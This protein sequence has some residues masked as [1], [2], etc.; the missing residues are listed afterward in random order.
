MIARRLRWLL[1]IAVCWPTVGAS[2]DA[3]SEA[4]TR[5]QRS[6]GHGQLPQAQKTLAP[7]AS[8]HDPRALALLGRIHTLRGERALAKQRY[9]SVVALYNRGAIGERDG[10]G[11][12][13]LATATAALGAYR[14]ANE[15]FARAVQAAPERLDIEL[16]WADL[17]IEK[18]ALDEAA[19]GVARVLAEAPEH[20]RALELHARI[21]LERGANFASVEALLTRALASDASLTAAHVTRAGLALRDEDVPLADGQ[22]DAALAIN[23]RDLEALSVRAA[24]RFVADDAPGFSRAVAAVLAQNARFSRL[25]SI[26]A[27]YAEWQH[28]YPELV[29]LSEAALAIDPGD[30]YA[31]AARGINLLRIGRE[32]EGLDALKQAWSRDHYNVQVFNLLELYERTLA[33]EYD[34]FDAPHFRLRMQKK[35]RMALAPYAV[36]LLGRAYDTLAKRY[37][38]TP[39]EPTYVELYASP[40][41][42]SIR[43]TGLPKLGVQGIC[44]GNVLIALSPRGGEFSWAQILWHELSHV[45]H[46]QLSKGRVPRWFTEGLAE[47]ET[48]LAEREWKR[49]D[50]RALYDALQRGA[51]PS[52]M[53]LNHA[54]THARRPDELMV[55]YYASALAVRYIAE[56]HGEQMLPKL[57]AL[58]GDGHDTGEVF[59]RAL[60]SELAEL[61]RDFRAALATRLGER[62]RHDMR[63]DLSAYRDLPAWRARSAARGATAD[64]HAGLALALAE[65]GE[66]EAA[67][68][69]ATALLQE[70]PA[71]ALARFTL[72]HVALKQGDLTQ[73][74][75][76]LDALLAAGHDGYQLRMLRARIAKASSTPRAAVP[77]LERAI[78]IDGDRSEAYELLSNIA[79]ELGDR[80]RLEWSLSREAALDQHARLPLLR[81]IALLRGR[82]AHAELVEPARRALHRDVHSVVLHVALAEGLLAHAHYGEAQREAE[83]ARTL[84]TPAERARV[85]ELLRAIE[86]AQRAARAP[87]RIET[88]P[89]KAR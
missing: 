61:D 54:F 62:Y 10:E 21:E 43:A 46:V 16:D 67:R 17:L 64:D 66:D 36:P 60:G 75:R 72:A 86:S 48:E 50:D 23:P 27:T 52:L 53:Q 70:Q 58:W 3:R 25:Y 40:E 33:Q 78:A 9:E 19:N 38:Y 31:H 39:S 71:H 65:A 22:L 20:A 76:E 29:A 63:V 2:A 14:D 15:T 5:A 87:A 47:Y 42:F 13:A 59:R 12:W 49:E 35:E 34:S 28:R 89:R 37:A 77:E 55:A 84:A 51:L 32:A 30:A 7:L 41:H 57:L 80:A 56:R 1:W 26:V 88:R 4:L 68:A 11:L 6:I 18:H 81:L 85:V 24:V 44:F 83:L 45:F 73:A 79:E 69:R 74:R 8:K 82:G